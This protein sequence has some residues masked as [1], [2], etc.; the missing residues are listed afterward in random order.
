MRNGINKLLHSGNRPSRLVLLL[1]VPAVLAGCSGGM[2]QVSG[3]V[4]YKGAAVKGG[5]LI[6]SPTGGGKPASATIKED[7]TFTAGTYNPGDGV[8]VGTHKV[9]F[10]APEP[11]LTEKQRTDP[12]YIAPPSPYGGLA[13]KTTEVQIKSGSNT[14]DI[15]LGPAPPPPP[16]K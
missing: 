15:E 13:P 8:L 11:V 16:P 4:T 3:K 14:I 6:F 2:G 7:G 10:T 5:T 1:L 12:N 9:S